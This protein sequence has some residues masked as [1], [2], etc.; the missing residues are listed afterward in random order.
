[1]YVHV[2]C[3]WEPSKGVATYTG[4]AYSGYYGTYMYLPLLEL[5]STDSV[6]YS[7]HSKWVCT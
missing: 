6:H 4:D 1:M 3:T 5:N 7:D 2:H